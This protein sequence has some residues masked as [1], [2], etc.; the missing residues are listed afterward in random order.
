MEILVDEVMER[1]KCFHLDIME[2][3]AEFKTLDYFSE[4]L[5]K[6]LENVVRD[7]FPLKQKN[8]SL[9]MYYVKDINNISEIFR[10]C[11]LSIK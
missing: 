2:D 6:I 5:E 3:N 4:T 7:K 8:N 11:Q 10:Y 1:I 9:E